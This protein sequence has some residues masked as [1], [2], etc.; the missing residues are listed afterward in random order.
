V[1]AKS[2]DDR[3][4]S[5]WRHEEIPQVLCAPDARALIL[6]Y[7]SQ[8]LAG[9][10]HVDFADFGDLDARYSE[11]G[12]LLADDIQMSPSCPMAFFISA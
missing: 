3:G 11:N 2:N 8:E 9:F 4:I 5:S 1:I 7:S 10:T 6:T 12:V